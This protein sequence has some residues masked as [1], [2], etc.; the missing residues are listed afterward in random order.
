MQDISDIID[1]LNAPQREAVTSPS[2]IL[3]IIA[4]AGS[5]K[6]RVL[7]QRMLWLM[8][9]E[10]VLPSGLLALTFT[11]KAAREMRGRLE[12]AM[13]RPMDGVR[14]GTFHHVC[15]R[16]LRQHA[17]RMNWPRGY[18]V[19]DSDD[20]LRMIKR[21][22]RDS[23]W[24]YDG[25]DEKDMRNAINGLKEEGV[26]S[27]AMPIASNLDKLI[28]EFYSD[29]ETA[30]IR[31]G[32][33][34]F[35]EMLL[36]TVELLQQH[37][38]IR[39][40]MHAR[41]RAILIDEF[42]DTNALQ[43]Q[44]VQLMLGK[45]AKL[46]VVGDDDQSIYS[47]RGA[48]IEN[49]LQLERYYPE[50]ET[51]R[52]E[53]NYRSTGIILAAANA[54][55]ANNAN[56]LGK[57]LWTDDADGE[58][59]ALYPALDEYDEARWIAE[60]IQ[61]DRQTG[62]SCRE[63]AVLYRTNAL[64]RVLESIFMEY[65]IPYRVT[66]GLRFFERAEIKDALAYL[67][68][69]ICPEDDGALERIINTPPRGIGEKTMNDLRALARQGGLPLWRLI[70][71]RT[72]LDR[73]FSARAANAMQN[74]ARNILI[75]RDKILAEPTLQNALTTVCTDSGLLN[76]LE[77]AKKDS[78]ESRIDNL[79]A[80]IDAGIHQDAQHPEP[81][82]EHLTDFLA[83]AALDA[84]ENEASEGEDAVQLMTLHTAKGLEF[85]HVYIIGMEE[86]IFPSRQS[87][88][89]EKL[90]EERRLA[91]VGITRAQKTL[92]L[93]FAERRRYHGSDT[94]PE[95][96]RFLQEI[97]PVH[98]D[99]IRPAAFSSILAESRHPKP[100]RLD[101]SNASGIKEGDLVEH[102]KFGEGCVLGFEG[103]GQS[104]RALVRFAGCGE[105]WL[106]LEFAPLTVKGR[107]L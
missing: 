40:G 88:Y 63:H 81:S 27:A 80:L 47:W 29:Y 83:D 69:V 106:I 24:Q 7:V 94:Y 50:L 102:P 42:Q 91:Y 65:D 74:F 82:L 3:R 25:F 57:D 99:S 103:Q 85:L 38:D 101:A 61:H 87:Q 2:R 9:A 32:R 35:A 11:N 23:G 6:T 72:L 52:L 62:G 59:I 36:L 90:E 5:G 60:R 98:L 44:F 54:V 67:R 92:A 10:K 78:S 49:I 17:D 86:N 51:I 31:Q 18:V 107:L 46:F 100:A 96:S 53:Q 68:T 43:F 30:C 77:S 64:S 48:R 13:Q 1:G 8:F 75:M 20:Q 22:M 71:D 45:D 37:K 58:K 97:P 28:C 66:G 12:E 34:D 55:I 4:G 89:S 104:L 56:R 14:M 73:H 76:Q 39:Q 21:M 84:G 93:S 19:M 105:K 15:G 26:R 95:P 41:Y 79:H 16:I 70:T 33:M